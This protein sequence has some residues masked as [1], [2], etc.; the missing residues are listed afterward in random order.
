MDLIFSF[1][2]FKL[3]PTFFYNMPSKVKFS[4]NHVFLAPESVCRHVL[5]P[6]PLRLLLALEPR[7]GTPGQ[8]TW[9]AQ[10]VGDKGQESSQREP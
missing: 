6:E 8:A 7:T 1:L 4:Y 3:I 2:G 10:T 9:A 5:G